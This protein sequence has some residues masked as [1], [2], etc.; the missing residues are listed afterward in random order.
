ME[1]VKIG[2]GAGKK[3]FSHA[4]ILRAMLVRE[5]KQESDVWVLESN[6]DDCTGEQLGFLQ[7]QLFA[8]GLRMWFFLPAYMKK[9][10]PVM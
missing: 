1:I 5:V 4:N 8:A 10:R 6:V 3:D 7:E 9:N 2:I